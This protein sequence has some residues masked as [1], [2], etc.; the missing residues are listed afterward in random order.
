MWVIVF[1]DL[2]YISSVTIEKHISKGGNHILTGD[3]RG[4]LKVWDTRVALNASAN[5]V[6]GSKGPS[7]S[8]A[9]SEAEER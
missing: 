1:R 3:A 2:I 6:N 4:I 8:L 7:R 5:A 9:E